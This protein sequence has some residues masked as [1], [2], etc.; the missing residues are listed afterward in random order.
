MSH[1]AP[2][3]GTQKE[4]SSA[5]A[6]A[7]C[8]ASGNVRLY[9]GDSLEIAPTLT[10]IGAVISDPPYGMN[11]NTNNKRFSGGATIRKPH[12]SRGKAWDARID[13]D[14]AD[15]DPT[16]WLTYPKVVLFGANHFG[17][18]LPVGTTLVWVKRNDAAFGTFL[19]DAEI[20]WMKGGHGIYCKRD[21]SMNGGGANF[22]KLHPTQ[23]TVKIMA[24]CMERAK[25]PAGDTV[26]D[27][28]MGSGT[29]GIACIRTGRGFVGIEKNPT[30][31]A[32]AVERIQREL[33]Q[34]D[35][36]RDGSP[37]VEMTDVNKERRTKA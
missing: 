35:F 3:M 8:W 23:K 7:D 22:E 6:L 25:V 33:S 15:F 24:W 37:N 20:A 4:A 21:V 31:F 12:H 27:P 30:H 28:Y 19:S 11:W 16:P 26:L 32:S 29:T 2:D 14:D 5:L 1:A 18:R 13:G 9:L 17:S 10:G 34:G 36:L